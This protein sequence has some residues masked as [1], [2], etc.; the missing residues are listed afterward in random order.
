MAVEPDLPSPS[1]SYFQQK[2][3]IHKSPESLLQAI[4]G[5]LHK[6]GGHYMNKV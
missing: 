3:C 1:F 6:D 5:P 4:Q 2:W